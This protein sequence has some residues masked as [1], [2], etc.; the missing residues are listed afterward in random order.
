MTPS[1]K[2]LIA[3]PA[4]PVTLLLLA[5][6]LALAGCSASGTQSQNAL[7]ALEPATPAEAPVSSQAA[8]SP[9]PASAFP[10]YV[11]PATSPASYGPTP[12]RYYATVARVNDCPAGQVSVIAYWH[13]YNPLIFFVGDPGPVEF[14][15]ELAENMEAPSPQTRVPV[16][17]DLV[18][19]KGKAPADQRLGGASGPAACCASSTTHHPDTAPE[20][21]RVAA[22]VCP[23]AIDDGL[24]R[25]G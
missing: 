12:R 21:Y 18:E 15:V 7:K 6:L 25:A 8:S 5:T 2:P 17:V 16:R 4:T 19:G 20:V 13:D 14:C 10:E 3:R 24:R 11:G 9:G 23:A 1:H 22:T